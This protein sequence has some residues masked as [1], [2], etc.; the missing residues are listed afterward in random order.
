MERWSKE[1]L[2]LERAMALGVEM[3]SSMPA[4]ATHIESYFTFC[5]AH[6]LSIDPTPDTLSFYIVYMSAEMAPRT[7]RTYLSG[8]IYAL[9]PYYPDA[10]RNRS[11]ILVSLTL[12]GCIKMY[13]SNR[14][15]LVK[16]RHLL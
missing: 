12:E 3:E 9:E 4:A 16:A 6:N 1:R 5:D 7:V 2:Q 14:K 8:V 15:V 11:S 10:K 13:S